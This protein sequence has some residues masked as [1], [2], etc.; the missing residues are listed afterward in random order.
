MTYVIHA[1]NLVFS[2]FSGNTTVGGTF[3]ITQTDNKTYLAGVNC[4]FGKENF[5]WI[6]ATTPTV[7]ESVTKSVQTLFAGFNFTSTLA[8]RGTNSLIFDKFTR[9]TCDAA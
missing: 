5:W 8:A 7:D 4:I 2:S 6:A 1:F 9:K 3:T